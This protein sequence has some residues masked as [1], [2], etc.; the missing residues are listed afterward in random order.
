[1]FSMGTSIP[2]SSREGSS[3]DSAPACVATNWLRATTEMNR[4]W[5]SMPARN[6][7]PTK[8]SRATLPRMGTSK[9]IAPTATTRSSCSIPRPR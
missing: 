2:D 6:R 5:P 1:M 9:I 8:K 7:K 3:D 4:P